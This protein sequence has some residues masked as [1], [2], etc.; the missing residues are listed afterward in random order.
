MATEP[1]QKTR[2]KR[3]DR[4]PDARSWAKPAEPWVADNRVDGRSAA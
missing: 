2:R 1:E 3:I 4:K